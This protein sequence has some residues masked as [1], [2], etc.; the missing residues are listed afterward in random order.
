MN[1]ARRRLPAVNSLLAAAEQAGLLQRFPRQV[2][3]DAIRA[4]LDSARG[5]G[6]GEPAHG[7]IEAVTHLAA[8]QSRL[9]LTRVVNATGVVL[10]TN[11]G[12]APLAAA[13]VA[14]A[15]AACGY[16]ALELDVGTGER[17][18]RQDHLRSLLRQITGA[19]DSLVVNNAAAALFLLLDALAGDGETIVSRGE[20]IEIGGSF[21]IPDI[22]A[23]SRS[24]LIEVGT[25]N[26]TRL[27]DYLQALSP[28]TRLIL[29]VHQSNFQTTGFVE[30]TALDELVSL[31]RSRGIPVLHDVGSGHVLDL[32]DWGLAG[33][34]R[35]QDSVAAGATVVFSGDKLLGGPQAGIIVGPEEVIGC[36]ASH[37]LARVLRPDKFTLAALEATLALYR[38]PAEAVVQIPALAMLTASREA[39]GERAARLAALLPQAT[40]GDGM[41]VVGGGAFPGAELPTVLVRVTAAAPDALLAA[42]RKYDPP[43]VARATVDGVLFDVRTVQD[44]EFATIAAAVKAATSG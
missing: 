18:S 6:G 32:S 11:L 10:H 39:L 25:T 22:L 35:V 17:G 20:L 7:W 14:A 5:T 23:K 26:R 27:R 15:E 37:P 30:E 42:L 13:A 44:G 41:S 40:T 21:R 28:R 31:G 1:D 12:R 36:A 33:E 3:V 43:I 16:S 8:E 2:V 9:S 29:K 34:P 38:D 24:T 19:A 4:I